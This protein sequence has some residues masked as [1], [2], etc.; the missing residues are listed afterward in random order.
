MCCEKKKMKELNCSSESDDSDKGNVQIF[1]NDSLN[2][3][4]ICVSNKN[5]FNVQD[6]SFLG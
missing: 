5:F 4:K 3:S 6:G 2:L 1:N